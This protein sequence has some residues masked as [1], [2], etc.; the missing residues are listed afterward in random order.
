[1]TV[2][3]LIWGNIN[4][5]AARA[6][7]IKEVEKDVDESGVGGAVALQRDVACSYEF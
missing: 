3:R 5:F 1:M 6:A 4:Q 2:D 7:A